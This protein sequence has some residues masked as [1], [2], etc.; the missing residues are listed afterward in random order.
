MLSRLKRLLKKDYSIV[1]KHNLSLRLKRKVSHCQWRIRNAYAVKPVSSLS[2]MKPS[3][4]RVINGYGT[5]YGAL[6]YYQTRYFSANNSNLTSDILSVSKQMKGKIVAR[7]NSEFASL[8]IQWN[9]QYNSQNPLFF[10]MCE[11][12]KDVSL[13]LKELVNKHNLKLSVRSTY[14]GGH[15]WV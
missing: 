10:A 9:V 8:D 3:Q 14:T 4:M 6:M 7:D 5:G 13:V 12:A 2:S 15:L 11:S 1:I